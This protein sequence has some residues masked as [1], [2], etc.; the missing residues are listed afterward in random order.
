M[1]E[2]APLIEKPGKEE[3]APTPQKTQAVA[4]EEVEQGMDREWDGHLLKMCGDCDQAGC[5]TFAYV[6]LL[7]PLA[8]G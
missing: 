5:S 4:V 7:T 6:K 2:A 8:W 1:E 3:K